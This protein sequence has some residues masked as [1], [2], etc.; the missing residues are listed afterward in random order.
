[1]QRL[2]LWCEQQLGKCGL[3]GTE[4]GRK[5]FS[6]DVRVTDSWCDKLKCDPAFSGMCTWA[7]VDA[8]CKIL[9]PIVK[10]GSNT[11]PPTPSQWTYMSPGPSSQTPTFRT[12]QDFSAVPTPMFTIK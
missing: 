6:K 5:C 2:Q 3:S 9:V 12:F 7:D 4:S 8:D 10:A 1:M 11:P